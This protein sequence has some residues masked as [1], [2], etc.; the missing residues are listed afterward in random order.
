MLLAQLLAFTAIIAGAAASDPA[1]IVDDSSGV[2]ERSLN[3]TLVT[4]GKQAEQTE[5]AERRGPRRLDGRDDRDFGEWAQS[6]FTFPESGNFYV[7][8]N[9]MQKDITCEWKEELANYN[10]QWYK[11]YSFPCSGLFWYPAYLEG[12]FPSLAHGNYIDNGQDT[13][14]FRGD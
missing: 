12:V 1:P 13:I 2:A 7:T 6:E 8:R 5:N 4:F 10:G 9:D 3:I 14:W 11:A